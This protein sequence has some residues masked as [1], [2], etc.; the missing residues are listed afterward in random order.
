MHYL[1]FN[2]KEKFELIKQLETVGFK[3][4]QSP[5][6]AIKIFNSGINFKILI[7]AYKQKFYLI[8]SD[9]E[10][11]DIVEED[12]VV[13]K[14]INLKQIL[15]YF[16][17]TTNTSTEECEDEEDE[18]EKDPRIENILQHPL[19]KAFSQIIP[20][21]KLK[22]AIEEAREQIRKENK[23]KNE[24]CSNTVNNDAFHTALV[25]GRIIQ[26]E[27]SGVVRFGIILSN[28]TVM[29]FTGNNLSA[30]GYI[31]N[32]TEDTP[33]RVVKIL[34][35]TSKY[36]NLKDINNMEVAWERKVVK[37]KVTKTVSEIEK[38]LGLAPGTLTIR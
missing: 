7:D 28:G 10:I 35:P 18:E 33:Y 31:N 17:I 34:K 25:P 21:E 9:N 6:T 24:I 12:S 1:L 19:M 2:D 32:I 15:S 26:F 38:E 5:T 16:G 13:Y 11:E 37:P 20:K 27:N 29:H 30:A 23:E 4:P 36:Y 8:V 3:N 14:D 22:E